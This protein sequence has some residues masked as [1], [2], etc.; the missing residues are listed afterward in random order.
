MS[1]VHYFQRYSSLE[2]M[3]TNNVLQLLARVYDYSAPHLS[4]LLTELIGIPVELGISID[5][6]KRIDGAGAVPDAT[7]AQESFKI[8]LEAKVDAPVD[9]AQ[10]VRHLGAFSQESLRVL[11]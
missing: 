8:V 5:Q 9:T 3:V 7:I 4:M 6:Q 2:N 1:K 11:L 10:L